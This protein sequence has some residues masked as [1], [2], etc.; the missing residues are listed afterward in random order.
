MG[1]IKINPTLSILTFRSEL[2]SLK[3]YLPCN[4]FQSWSTPSTK[5]LKDFPSIKPSSEHR[6]CTVNASLVALSKGIEMTM[7]A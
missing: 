3:N 4:I 1:S 5:E 2:L 6:Y 7:L